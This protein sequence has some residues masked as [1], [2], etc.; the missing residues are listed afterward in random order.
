M[1]EK[2]NNTSVEEVCLKFKTDLSLN[3]FS[4]DNFE[5][6]ILLSDKK[7]DNI[8]CGEY[9]TE[10]LLEFMLLDYLTTNPLIKTK[11]KTLRNFIFLSERFLYKIFR[12]ENLQITKQ[13][14]FIKV[15]FD[16]T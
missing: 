4:H 5:H 3:S 6:K 15:N 10:D 2:D 1:K 8:K 12:K 14:N 9:L 16:S 7:L 11:T 13:I